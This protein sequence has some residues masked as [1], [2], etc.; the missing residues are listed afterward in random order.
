M[1][2]LTLPELEL[3]DEKTG[4]F[5]TI[6]GRQIPLEHNLVSVSKWE[7]KWKIPFL[8]ST[9]KT[10]AQSRDYIRCMALVDDVDPMLY[11]NLT[12]DMIEDIDKYINDK[13][14]ATWFSNKNEQSNRNGR[15]TTSELIYYWMIESG[16]P[17]ECENW[18]L[19]R[20]LTLIEVVNEERK[21]ADPNRNHKINPR[22][23]AKSRSAL[24][25]QRRA[26]MHSK[27]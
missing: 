16:V 13:Q 4:T 1:Y 3:F 7:S 25:A 17:M 26:M 14:T 21:A 10:L 12:S 27:G 6:P 5:R 24:N 18:H 11:M 2:L 22:D 8:S 19:S 20:L 9:Q 15:P 23:Y